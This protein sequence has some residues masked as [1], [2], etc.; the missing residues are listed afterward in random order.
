MSKLKITQIQSSIRRTARQRACL[1]GL[2]IR[3]ISHTVEVEDTPANRGMINKVQFMLR[4][5]SV[6]NG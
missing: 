2:G 5:E 6:K 4:V 3:R 1:A